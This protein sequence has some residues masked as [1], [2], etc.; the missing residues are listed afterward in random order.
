MK[1]F[2][3]AEVLIV[4]VFL[5]AFIFFSRKKLS[6]VYL[7][8]L[9]AII[10]LCGFVSG[11]LINLVSIPTEPVTLTALDEK[12]KDATETQ[13]AIS[14]I[15]VDDKEYEQKNPSEGKWFWRGDE[16][17]W[18]TPNDSRQPEGVTKTI[19]LDI[20]IGNSRKIEFASYF[21]RG[22]VEVIS[23]NKT[24]IVDTYR[25]KESP[26][27]NAY[28]YLSPTKSSKVIAFKLFKLFLFAIIIV[29]LS[30]YPI[31]AVF[32]F[33]RRRVDGWIGR[34][35][36]KLYYGTI[37]IFYVQVLQSVSAEGS[38]WCDELWQ[39][40]W[41]YSNEE[42]Y[43]YLIDK[44]WFNIMPYG[45]Q[46]LR[47]L[48]QLFV[49]ATIFLVGMIGAEYK[50][51]K[52]GIIFSSATAFSLTIVNQCGMC[53]RGY[54]KL[55]FAS[56][57][58]LLVY[59]RKQKNL[60]KENL[61]QLFIYGFV[62][63]LFMDVHQFGLVA[64]GL[65]MLSD[66]MLI[67]IKKASKKALAEFVIPFVYGVYWLFKN[68]DFNKATFNNYSWAGDATFSR[69]FDGVQW[70][71]CYNNILLAIFILEFFAI[72]FR[73]FRKKADM[74]FSFDKDYTALIIAVV[75]WT[76]V[77]C[78][79][80]YSTVINSDN[81]LFIDRYFISIIIWL[82]FT[83]SYGIYE[84]IAITG[85]IIKTKY[86]QHVILSASLLL[87]CA[88]N[89]SQV[90]AWDKWGKSYRT[91]NTDFKSTTEYVMKQGDI[92]EKSS[93]YIIDHH[94]PYGDIGMSYYIMHKDQRD[95]INHCSIV[96]LPSD[97]DNYSTIYISYVY[98][99]DRY[100][101]ELNSIIDEEFKLIDDN[102]TAK[103]KKYVRK[104]V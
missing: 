47:L 7:V 5:A 63:S 42:G 39:L 6:K 4:I 75:P 60:G 30:F 78:T 54:A 90:S 67:I 58:V 18:R 46:Y 34:N 102:K 80:F 31:F 11:K 45:Q 81:S 88:Y 97:L 62:L 95:D 52:F 32:K 41:Y 79:Y 72:V 82:Y 68:W 83:L 71:F 23:G 26:N 19:V 51:K 86:A 8:G 73:T 10:L 48:P 103:V 2:F 77:A 3:I 37:S 49:A 44:L 36:D 33:G 43:R 92:Y 28:L 89:W 17:W 29:L 9:S 22:M 21:T 57:L 50:D 15:I 74:T 76:L 59:I 27:V 93:L 100:N 65:I 1:P 99:G 64:A 66:L 14:K 24:S 98:R 35:W 53:I 96:A 91:A 38:F 16:L 84:M 56:A 101:A 61:K 40:G 25:P 104:N 69:L 94:N 70:L 55:L 12:N 87:L 20:P 13:I 85:T